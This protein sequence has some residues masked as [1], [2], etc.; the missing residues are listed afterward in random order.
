MTELDR[1]SSAGSLWDQFP[2]EDEQLFREVE[3]S[4][5]HLPDNALRKSQDD[6]VDDED[7]GKYEAEYDSLVAELSQAKCSSLRYSSPEP[8]ID[9]EDDISALIAVYDI[10]NLGVST[11]P[12]KSTSFASKKNSEETLIASSG[13]KRTKRSR[14]PFEVS[15]LDE[16]RSKLLKT[17]MGAA[18]GHRHSVNPSIVDSYYAVAHSPVWQPIFDQL[19]LPFGV[20]WEISRLVSGDKLSFDRIEKGMIEKLAHLKTNSRAAPLVEKIFLGKEGNTTG[21]RLLDQL[22]SGPHV[23]FYASLGP[24]EEGESPDGHLDPFASERLSKFPYTELDRE[25]DEF[26]KGNTYACLGCLDDDPWYGGK[27]VFRAKVKNIA[28]EYAKN[29]KFKVVLDRPELGASYRFSRRHGSSA[30]IRLKVPRDLCTTKMIPHLIKF[31]IQPMIFCGS[32]YR[33]VLEKDKTVFLYRTNEVVSGLAPPPLLSRRLMLSLEEFLELENP[34]ELNKNQAAAKW[35]TR[36]GLGFSTSAPGVKLLEENIFEI[37]DI[38]SPERSEMT[39]GS[40]FINQYAL[41][42]LYHRFNW[43]EWPTAIQVRVGG[44]KGM[45]LQHPEDTDLVPRIWIRP[46]QTKIK[47]ESRSGDEARLV[48]DILRSCHSRTHCN[49][50]AETIINLAENGVPAKVFCRLMDSSFQRMMASLTTWEGDEA[51]FEL[52]STLERLGGV[53]AARAARA[54]PGL[55]RVKGHS[56]RD[57]QIDGD[58]DRLDDN[59]IEETSVA[60]WNDEISGQPSSLEETVM[61]LLDFGFTPDNCAVLLEKLG[62][63]ITTHIRN[64]WQQCKIEVP[65]SCTTFIQPDPR[66]FLDEGQVYFKSAHRNLLTKEGLVTDTI[67]GD[68]LVTR[69]PCKLPTDVQKWEAV[70]CPQLRNY[71]GIIFFSTKGSRRAADYLGGVTGDYDGDK[72]LL[73]YDPVLVD[74]FDNAD[75]K[76]ADPRDDIEQDYFL[77]HTEKLSELL[78]KVQPT[79]EQ[80]Q[81][82]L[83]AIQ[84]Y[85]LG[86][87]KDCSLVGQYSNMHDY[88]TYTLGYSHPETIRLAHMFCRTLDGAKTGLTV[89]APKVAADRRRYY[90]GAMHWKRPKSGSSSEQTD[91]KRPRLLGPFVMDE[92]AKHAEARAKQAQRGFE[93]KG[94]GMRKHVPDPHLLAPWNESRELAERWNNQQRREDMKKI[95]E[96]VIYMYNKHRE[97]VNHNRRATASKAFMGA[98]TFTD[99]P[100]ETRQ[101]QLREMSREFAASPSL[102]EVSLMKAELDCLRASFAYLYDSQVNKGRQNGGWTRFPWDVAMRELG[103]I[104]ATALGPSKTVRGEFYQKFS[105]KIRRNRN[106]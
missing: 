74:R 103:A 54:Q 25:E 15:A 20:Q 98:K 59:D 37:D 60:W 97:Q 101:N 75:I 2:S 32:V 88:A 92:I 49:L 86:G 31:L 95:E 19:Q 14:D 43:D 48:I 50:G 44:A 21:S 72:A 78:E 68:V 42:L 7:G 12:C 87:L 100:I 67:I 8:E 65:M 10:S 34:I 84:G 71:T 94:G 83:H 6:F 63:I 45:L 11:Q 81:A 13:I 104:K 29:P 64:F 47:Y 90:K 46:S 82:R 28:S 33:L 58:E 55:A 106:F 99:Q 38:V 52:W 3:L 102:S 80:P 27:V 62:Q 5:D 73:I 16:P 77:K 85:L 66:G 17:E 18:S 9:P 4:E 91:V 41:R 79:A 30:F 1:E 53:M 105:V 96:H 26:N 93:Q 40:G 22:L 39:D 89:L 76:F 57:A 56:S 61:A 36:F 69:H 51:M 70:D 23:S 35:A 24:I